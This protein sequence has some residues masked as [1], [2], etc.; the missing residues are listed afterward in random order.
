MSEQKNYQKELSMGVRLENGYF[1]MD[2]DTGFNIST[3][4]GRLTFTFW[5]KGE[6]SSDNANPNDNKLTLNIN[7]VIILNK[8]LAFI[9][10]NRQSEY[11]S[12]GIEGYSN[13]TNISLPIQ[14]MISNQLITFGT[15][16]FDTVEVE[17]I[18]RLKMT[19]SKD[20]YNVS[21]VFCDKYMKNIFSD[22]SKI[23]LGYDIFDTSFLR[24][25]TEVNNYLNFSWQ[26]GAFNKL[27]NTI[28]GKQNSNNSSY[29]KS[30]QNVRYNS[31][32]DSSSPQQ[33]NGDGG[34]FDGDDF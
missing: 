32:Q 24:L 25:C 33:S 17:G 12:K 28:A 23:K 14:G 8:I 4:S 30:Q 10:Q 11:L 31:S 27:F 15:I 29:N 9:I 7:Q 20:S 19:V 22:T 13:I 3:F 18:N 6:K 34:L 1:S 5:K 16:R 21:F 26:M 2:G